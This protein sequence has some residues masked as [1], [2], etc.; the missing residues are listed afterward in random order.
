M[1][2]GSGATDTK[3]LTITLD[4][5]NDTPVLTASVTAHTF[6]DTAAD[7]SFSAVTGTLSRDDRDSGDSATYSVTGGSA[8]TPISGFDIARSTDY[9]TL[10]L[11]SATGAYSFVPNDGAI[12]GLKT[13]ATQS[14]TFTVTDGSGA[15]DTKTLTITL[16]GAND[17]PVLTASVTAHTFTDTAADDS[18]SAV[19]GT[20]SRDD[21]DSGDS[22]TYSVSGGS[23]GTPISGFDIARSTDYGTLYLNSAT[24]AYTFIPNDGAIEG[25]KTAATQSFTFTVTDGSGATDT[26]T[27]TITLDGANDTPVLTA[28][29]TAHTFTD[30]AADDSFSAVTGTLSRD[31]RDSGDSAVYSVTGGSAGTPISGFDIARST[32]YG[33]LYLNSTTGAY[34][35]IPNDG[36]IEG[37]KTAATQSFTFT[38]TDGSGAT[39]T[40]TLTI[41]LDGANDTPVLTAPAGGTVTDTSADDAFAPVTGALSSTDRD[42]GDTAVF[43]LTGGS[44]DSSLAGFDLSEATA[45][46]KLFVNSV[47]GA[48]TF[49]ADDA[50]V[51]GLRNDVTLDFTVSVTDGS[52]ASDS[53]TLTITLD[54]ANDTPTASPDVSAPLAENAGTTLDVTANDSDRDI[55][56]T[57]TVTSL[58]IGSLDVTGLGVLT[59]DEMDQLRACFTA[60][61]SNILF[62][63]GDG[64]SLNSSSASI[65]DRLDPGQ[66]SVIT[67]TYTVVD[68]DGAQAVSTATF[69]IDG[70]YE[71]YAA[72]GSDDTITASDYADQIT[73]GEGNDSVIAKAGNDDINGG[74]G[75]DTLNG[76]AGAD[77]MA[78]GLGDDIFNVDN[79]GD[80]VIEVAGE[81]NDTVFAAINYV[82]AAD[83]D[84]ETL[85]VSGSAGRTLTGNG[86]ANTL[87]GGA[88]TDTLN[89]AGGDDTLNGLAGADVMSGGFGDDK[90]TVDNLSDQIIETAGQGVDTVFANAD[91]TLGA[92]VEVELLRVNGSGSRVLTGNE[93]ANQILGGNSADVLNGADGNDSL[94][95]GAGADSMAGGLGDDS[96]TVD[97]ASDLVL[98]AASGGNDTLFAT[99]NYIL[100]AG[101]EV[102]NLRVQGGGARTLTGNNLDN[103]IFGLNA[104]DTLNGGGGD[105]TLSGAGGA[106]TMRG[107]A[108]NDFYIV[109]QSGDLVFEALGEGTDTITARVNFAMAAN[110]EIEVL[111][112]GVTTGLTLSGNN[113]ANSILGNNGADTLSGGGGEDKIQGGAG[114][115][116]LDG[117][118]GNDSF[119]YTAV[120]ESGLT[121]PGRDTITAF[122][123][124]DKVDVRLIDA[125]TTIANNQGFVLDTNASFSVGEIRQT[126]VNGGADLLI[127]F[128][129][130]ADADADMAILLTGRGASFLTSVDFVL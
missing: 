90:Y 61:G 91:Y 29:V 75:N 52:G 14:F 11:N 45:Y 104:A 101:Q 89:G 12:E 78:G 16:D 55:G 17:T 116:V 47:T 56:D 28:S 58:T 130:D 8:G 115:D 57:R 72:N 6:T 108:G 9:G 129:N 127:E 41:T 70:A 34:T 100:A 98:E 126:A 36:A 93:L 77:K 5:A 22:A 33:T 79:A 106:D 65:F 82:L 48:Y 3:T 38:V 26:K 97:N 121:A 40:K 95:G 30:T 102:E 81:G 119:V 1:T 99:V 19:T 67:V 53:K 66:Q 46:G 103:R 117:G 125:N 13:A 24:G 2:D 42:A 68:A 85:R 43:G 87:L 123:S 49:V 20:L 31:D 10:Y 23:A 86:L 124:G 69:T 21:R 73:A 51:E 84:I 94:N 44:A 80:L 113:L 118:L 110:Q 7:D 96:F 109:E 83:A 120:T 39:D 4:G 92:G 114:G 60:S 88:G 27:L 15:T 122:V 64:L 107:N 50:A 63:P 111:R 32:D 128:N 35:F 105:D 25:L 59:N 71:I 112:S 37:L 62:A 18:F 74:G 76:G 54:G